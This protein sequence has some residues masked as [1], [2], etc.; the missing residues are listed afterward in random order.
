MKNIIFASLFFCSGAFANPLSGCWVFSNA[1]STYEIDIEQKS[2]I[3]S[4]HYCFIN[5]NG[6]RIDCEKESSLI[7]GVIKDEVGIISFGGSGK[8]QLINKSGIVILNMID[9]TPFDNFNMHI[10]SEIRLTRETA[11]KSLPP[12]K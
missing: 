7:N 3:I 9:T 8:G 6:N 11:C 12:K 1:S 10:P 4:G 2:N 5:S